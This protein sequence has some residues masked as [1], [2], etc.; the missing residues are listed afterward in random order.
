MTDRL[1]TV[2]DIL[3]CE[4][5]CSKEAHKKI[6]AMWSGEHI[7]DVEKSKNVSALT[8]EELTLMNRLFGSDSTCYPISDIDLQKDI[9]KIMPF[10]L[11]KNF[12]R[13]TYKRAMTITVEDWVW[14][15]SERD[16]INEMDIELTCLENVVV[17]FLLY[18]L[19]GFIVPID[20]QKRQMDNWIKVDVN[21]LFNRPR[22]LF[23]LTSMSPAVLTRYVYWKCTSVL[24]G[25]MR[26]FSSRVELSDIQHL[27]EQLEIKG[28]IDGSQVK[29]R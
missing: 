2:K 7:E 13:A 16:F 14:T 5:H 24:M 15:E 26:H 28:I 17:S 3:Y 6:L 20:H 4:D 1:S 18:L 29:N 9:L 8:P 23:L 19:G 27:Q 10:D 12:R 22:E 21:S 11:Y 25:L